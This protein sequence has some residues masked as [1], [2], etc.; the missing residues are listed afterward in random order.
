MNILITNIELS[1]PTGTVTYISD[2]A[3]A[4]ILRG[5]T[6][7]IFTYKIGAIGSIL[8]KQGINVVTKLSRLQLVPD[9]IHC[10][11]HPTA[12]DCIKKF[13]R[14]PAVFF[15]HDRTSPLDHPPKSEQIVKYVAVDHNCFERFKMEGIDESY[16]CVIHNWVNTKKFALREFFSDKPRNAVLF[17]NY[18]TKKNYFTSI[19]EACISSGIKLDVLGSGV[20]NEVNNPED[21]LLQYDLVFGKAKSAIEA[22]STGAAVIVCDFM[23]LGAMVSQSNITHLIKFNFGMKTLTRPFDVDIIRKEIKKFDSDQNKFNAITIR[24][25][26]SL[27]V[28]INSII[29]LYE[30]TIEEYASGKRGYRPDMRS[31]NAR[32]LNLKIYFYMATKPILKY[33]YKAWLLIYWKVKD[34]FVS[35]SK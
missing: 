35:L 1:K 32:A 2:L 17:S 15:I 9:I 3:T 19:Q 23:G 27:D 11:H 18:A 29:T 6:V 31:E 22:L 34:T 21:F 8:K 25:E 7:E 5:H 14:T 24:Q 30:N 33:I 16:C 10:H 12:M 13:K 28:I 26:S 4:L 20:G